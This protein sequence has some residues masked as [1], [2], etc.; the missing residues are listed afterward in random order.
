MKENKNIKLSVMVQTSNL[1]TQIAEAGE[2]FVQHQFGLSRKNTPERLK[3]YNMHTY[4]HSIHTCMHNVHTCK[5]TLRNHT[6]A[7]ITVH[8]PYNV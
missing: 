8:T 2:S 1:S 3:T 5:H 6:K 4:T 7:L